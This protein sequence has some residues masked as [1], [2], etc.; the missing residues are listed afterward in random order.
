MKVLGGVCVGGGNR[1]QRVLDSGAHM[2][3]RVV[4]QQ[5][6]T[7]CEHALTVPVHSSMMIL[8]GRVFKAKVLKVV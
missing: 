7:P 4:M 3:M 2:E 6:N 8:I 1:S 5:S